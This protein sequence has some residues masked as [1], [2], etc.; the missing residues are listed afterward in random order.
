M[1]SQRIYNCLVGLS[2]VLM[3]TQAFSAEITFERQRIGVGTY[4]AGAICDINND[5]AIEIISGYN[6]EGTQLNIYH[7]QDFDQ[8]QWRKEQIDDGIGMGQMEV[9]DLNNNGR[10][11]I[12]ATGMSTGNV[13]WYENVP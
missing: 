11:D 12:A 13:R 10:L 8:N 6:G 1:K 3:A 9:T 2:A 5:G 4:E 7:P